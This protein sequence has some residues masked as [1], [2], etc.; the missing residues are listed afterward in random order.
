MLFNYNDGGRSA[1]GYKG[2][3]R[4]C[5]CRAIAIAT[6]QNYSDVYDTLVNK[7]KNARQTRRIKNS[8]PRTGVNKIVY[9]PYL[10]KL[11]WTWVPCM[12]IGS[13]CQTHLKDNELPSG[14]LI[15]RVSKHLTSVID[16]IINDTFDCS[17][18]G[19]RCVYGYFIKK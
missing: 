1:A 4:D 11:G 5:V 6:G 12:T 10:E 7:I 18:D 15:V 17:R 2:E 14:R 8:H 9:K 19:T 13:G 16:G 3:T